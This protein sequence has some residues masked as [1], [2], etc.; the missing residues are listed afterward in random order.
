MKNILA[1]IKA[2]KRNDLANRTLDDI[3]KEIDEF[4]LLNVEGATIAELQ[5]K[6]SSIM[7]GHTRTLYRL[8]PEGIFRARKNENQAEFNLVSEVSYP[9]WNKIPKA[10]HS[11]GRCHDLGEN[12]CYCATERD[13]VIVEVNPKL[14][15]VITLID[16]EV[17]PPLNALI[18]PIG[19]KFLQQQKNGYKEIFKKHYPDGNF[20]EL[21]EKNMKIESFLDE[22]FHETVPKGMEWKYNATIAISKMLMSSG[23]D[24]MSFCSIS[25]KLNGVNFVFRPEIADRHF[26]IVNGRMYKVIEAIGNRLKLQAIKVLESVAPNGDDYR[27]AKITW[28]DTIATDREIELTIEF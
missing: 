21:F 28:R 23:H 1:S 25:A 2:N 17:N 15:D 16:F 9:D 6:L 13:T 24:G 3:Q 12:G 5:A 10:A 19:I 26:T 20:D 4:H 27:D 18:L 7:T 8:N 14:H 22:I 11:K